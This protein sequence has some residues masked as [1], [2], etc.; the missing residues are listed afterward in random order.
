MLIDFS[1]SFYSPFRL[2]HYAWISLSY[3]FVNLETS[4]ILQFLLYK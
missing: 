4:Q 3:G 2:L 1:V